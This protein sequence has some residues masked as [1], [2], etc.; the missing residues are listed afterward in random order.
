MATHNII[1]TERESALIES[2]VQSGRYENSSEA[3]REGLRLLEDR[4]RRDVS[5]IGPLRAAID[6]GLADFERGDVKEFADVAQLIEHLKSVAAE[7]RASIPARR[8]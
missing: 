1:L 6:V 8:D 3:L 5:K 2:L 4:E 7:A